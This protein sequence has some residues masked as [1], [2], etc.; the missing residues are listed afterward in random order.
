MHLPHA[1]VGLKEVIC[2][3][4]ISLLTKKLPINRFLRNAT[5]GFPLNTFDKS[6]S[7]LSNGVGEVFEAASLV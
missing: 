1:S 5:M 6:H 2:G 4:F 7:Q 3:G